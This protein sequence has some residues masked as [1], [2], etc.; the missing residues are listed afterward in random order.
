[1]ASCVEELT[2]DYKESGNLPKCLSKYCSRS[3]LARCKDGVYLLLIGI[4]WVI[5][6][7]NFKNKN[8]LQIGMYLLYSQCKLSTYLGLFMK[9]DSI[10]TAKSIDEH[11]TQNRYDPNWFQ[12][13]NWQAMCKALSTMW[14]RHFQC[15]K[16]KNLPIWHLPERVKKCVLRVM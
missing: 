6:K 10:T 3:Q 13:Q 5:L 9:D 12:I 4:A 11:M 15:G 1:M 14:C 16:V 7:L 2:S 8:P